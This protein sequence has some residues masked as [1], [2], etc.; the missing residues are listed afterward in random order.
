[1]SQGVIE[2]DIEYTTFLNLRYEGTDTSLMIQEPEDGNYEEAFTKR[3]LREFSFAS[4][5]KRL[6]IDGEFI[7]TVLQTCAHPRHPSHW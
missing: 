5:D 3:H 7:F 2:K 6:V 1:M 4:K